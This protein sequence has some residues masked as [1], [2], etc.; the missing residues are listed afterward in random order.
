MA[1]K[2]VHVRKT[3]TKRSDE[4]PVNRIKEAAERAG[5]TGTQM[6]RLP[7]VVTIPGEL[8]RD[9]LSIIGDIP[10][11]VAETWGN[12][13]E[14]ADEANAG[15]WMLFNPRTPSPDKGI[16]PF[17]NIEGLRR[18]AV[19]GLRSMM[20]AAEYAREELHTHAYGYCLPKSAV[21]S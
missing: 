17:D 5:I 15:T 21:A 9:V 18:G 14:L 1:K 8:L 6:Q 13:E 12:V 7:E 20:A 11:F 3:H 10:R 19:K 4:K 16:E 2:T